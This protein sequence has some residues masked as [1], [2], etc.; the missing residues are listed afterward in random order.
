MRVASPLLPALPNRLQIRFAAKEACR[1]VRSNLDAGWVLLGLRDKAMMSDMLSKTILAF[2]SS[3]QR[4]A[5]PSPPRHVDSAHCWLSIRAVL[6]RQ[7]ARRKA[8]LLGGLLNIGMGR[9]YL[10][11]RQK[12]PST[13]CSPLP[14]TTFAASSDGPA[15]CCTKSSHR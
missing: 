8:S 3:D 9:N 13:P 1:A 15:S 2:S 12:M 6:N 10:W 7:T 11:H 14:A 5:G 4:A